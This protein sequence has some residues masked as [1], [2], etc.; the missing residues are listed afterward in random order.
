[1][2]MVVFWTIPALVAG[3]WLGLTL[4]DID[5]RTTLLV[6]RSII[7]HGPLIPTSIYLVMRNN[8]H[9]QGRLFGMCVCLGFAVHMGFDLFPAAWT[10][11]ALISLP[12]YGWLPAWVSI[13]WLT[14]SVLMCAYWATRLTRGLWEATL[15]AIGAV[16]IFLVAAPGER[17][18]IGPL[19]VVALSLAA[20]LA[21][22]LFRTTEG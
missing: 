21:M 18:L 4:P 20:P 22:S 16:C 12:A 10:G 9:L 7:T 2:A 14:T 17:A 6:H 13:L 3:A 19:L 5:Q 11:Y 8:D 1:M 15:L